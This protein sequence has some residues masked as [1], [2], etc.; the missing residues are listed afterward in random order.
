MVVILV[1][2]CRCLIGTYL[3]ISCIIYYYILIDWPSPESLDNGD[4]EKLSY[5]MYNNELSNCRMLYTLMV[6]WWN[7]AD[8]ALTRI[9]LYLFLQF[10]IFQ[11]LSFIFRSKCNELKMAVVKSR[12][13]FRV[14]WKCNSLS[15]NHAP[16]SESWCFIYIY[17]NLWKQWSLFWWNGAD[18]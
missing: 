3:K 18:V 9:C 1:E 13:L 15:G 12:K 6:F 8:Q 16:K 5:Q 14:V 10:C 17:H 7:G 4:Y 2:R 11:L